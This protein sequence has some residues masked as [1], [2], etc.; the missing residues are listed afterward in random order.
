MASL[1]LHYLYSRGLFHFKV[2]SNR[3][4]EYVATNSE[5][6]SNL[7]STAERQASGSSEDLQVVEISRK[8]KIE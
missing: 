2:D 3:K 6:E 7:T 8:S 1:Q 5:T 4:L